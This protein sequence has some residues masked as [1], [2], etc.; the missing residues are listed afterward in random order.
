MKDLLWDFNAQDLVD[1]DGSL[2]TV[3][4]GD[5]VT[6]EI[7]LRIQTPYYHAPLSFPFGSDLVGAVLAPARRTHVLRAINAALGRDPFVLSWD[8]TED[9]EGYGVDI[10]LRTGEVIRVRV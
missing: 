3:I 5:A 8:V 9:D 10:K 2:A 1:D 6:Q 4:D 7:A